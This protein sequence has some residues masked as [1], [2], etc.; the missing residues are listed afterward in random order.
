MLYSRAVA[1]KNLDFFTTT[2]RRFT[3]KI[4]V[5]IEE[6]DTTPLSCFLAARTQLHFFIMS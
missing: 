2:E 6:F 5:A 4:P 1:L 3:W